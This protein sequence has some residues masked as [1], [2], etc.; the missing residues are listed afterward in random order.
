[1]RFPSLV[2]LDENLTERLET[3]SLSSLNLATSMSLCQTAADQRQFFFPNVNDLRLMA[4]LV[5]LTV[6]RI[7]VILEG[8]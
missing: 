6:S 4:W 1:M 2:I 8:L 3:R 5:K 7:L